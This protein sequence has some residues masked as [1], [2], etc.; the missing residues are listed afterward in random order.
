[1]ARILF[2]EDEQPVLK[3][4]LKAG[5]RFALGSR[6]GAGGWNGLRDAAIS[7]SRATGDPPRPGPRSRPTPPR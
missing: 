1:M 3:R 2:V 6:D 4:L 7:M 5:T